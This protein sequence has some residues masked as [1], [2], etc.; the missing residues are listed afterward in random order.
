MRWLGSPPISM[1][2]ASVAL[3]PAVRTTG[4]GAPTLVSK[5]STLEL[6]EFGVVNVRYSLSA[7]LVPPVDLTVMP[8]PVSAPTMRI[9]YATPPGSRPASE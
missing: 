6:V 3:E 4:L 7:R 1:Y 5:N 2:V 9:S 8:V